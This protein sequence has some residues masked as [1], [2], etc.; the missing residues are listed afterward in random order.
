MRN[1]LRYAVTRILLTIPMVLILLTLVFVVLRVMPGDPVSAMLGGHAPERVIQEKKEELGLNRPLIVQY[2]E[3][4]GQLIRLDLGN[5]MI[6]NQKVTQPIGEKLAATLELTLV[7]MLFT[8]LIG[9]PLGAYA[10]SRRRTGQ[11]FGIRLYGI[12]FYCI[13]VFWM[14]LML[15]LIFGIWL[16]WLP[17]SGRTSARVLVST[18]EV[19][20]FYTIDSLIRGNI[21]AFGDVLVH[22]FL[23]SLTLGLVLSGVFVRLTRANMLDVLKSDYVLAAR[24][25]GI[26]ERKVVYR[27]ALKNAFIPILTML[28]LQFAIL[29]SGAILTENT[30]SWPG[31]GRLLVERIYLRDY[32]TVQGVIAV[33]AIMVSAISLLVDLIYALID[34]RVRY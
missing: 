28:G 6:Y 10:A 27:H 1:L 5:S 26:P 31:M 18:F 8:L 2:F 32:P 14:G 23:P 4:L 11:D 29:L 3:Y 20:G 12:V 25:R 21:A 7:G 15:Q 9:V 30:F 33:F 16:R 34:P 13:P 19:T 17:I 22:L 24:A